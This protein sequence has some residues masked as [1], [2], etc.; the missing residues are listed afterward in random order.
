MVDQTHIEP[1][2]LTKSDLKDILQ[3][4]EEI[5]VSLRKGLGVTSSEIFRLW[6]QIKEIQKA[7]IQ[8]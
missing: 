5:A 4:M 8:S 2:G 7:D 3:D 1:G 6:E